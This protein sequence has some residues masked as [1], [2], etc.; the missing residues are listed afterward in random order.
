MITM[1]CITYGSEFLGFHSFHNARLCFIS[2][3]CKVS[4][5]FVTSPCVVAPNV[6]IVIGI[7]GLSNNMPQW[8][9]GGGQPWLQ[10]GSQ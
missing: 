7:Q 5:K 10:V 2:Y 9:Q 1:F 4:K 3:C 8:S 6:G